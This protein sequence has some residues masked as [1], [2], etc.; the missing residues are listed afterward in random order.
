MKG[1]KCYEN[2]FGNWLSRNI[3]FLGFALAIPSGE[4]HQVIHVDWVVSRSQQ[5]FMT[6]K[7]KLGVPG[8]NVGWRP[9]KRFI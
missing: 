7:L 5:I 2:F 3:L 6:L 8:L 1:K 9:R 4:F